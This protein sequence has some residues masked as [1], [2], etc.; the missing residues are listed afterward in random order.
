MRTVK[1]LC[2]QFNQWASEGNQFVASLSDRTSHQPAAV[3]VSVKP[4][5][6]CLVN[7]GKVKLN[8]V[9]DL[10]TSQYRNKII[11]NMIRQ[12][13]NEYDVTVHWIYLEAGHG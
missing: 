10:P 9:S 4:V 11:F 7:K 2:M 6:E 8:I 12:F 13:A 5:L 1:F 3:M